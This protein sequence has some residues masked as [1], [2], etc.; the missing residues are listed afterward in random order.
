MTTGSDGAEHRL[1]GRQHGLAQVAKSG[2]AMI[3]GRHVHGRRMRSGTLVGAWNL[4]E[5]TAAPECHATLPSLNAVY[6]R[7]LPRP[8]SHHTPAFRAPE[9]HDM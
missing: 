6:G 5:V 4:E 7:T 1:N 8:H 3:H 2:A 9:A